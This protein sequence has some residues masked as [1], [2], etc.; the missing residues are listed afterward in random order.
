MK[1]S[2]VI[3]A[4]GKGERMRSSWPKV[5]H[6]V[7]GEAMLSRVVKT[8]QQLDPVDI[9]VVYGSVGSKV[10]DHMKNLPVKWVEQNK[11]LG[12]GHA[13]LQAIEHIAQDHMVL[14]LYADVPLVSVHTLQQLQQHT[15]K[16]GVGVVVAHLDDPTGFGRIVRNDMGHIIGIVEHK[17]ATDVQR[18]IRE[19]N[20]GIMMTQASA[21]HEWLPNLGQQNA[22]GEYYL[23]D[24]IGLAVSDGRSVGGV[25]AGSFEEV[26]GVNN[27]SQLAQVER[28]YQRQQARRLMREGVTLMD[29]SRFDLR[30][31]LSAGQDT[32]IDCNVIVEGDNEWG[33]E[34]SVGAGS[35]LSNVTLGDGVK[36]GAHCVIRD[37]TIAVGTV[38]K[39]HSVIEGAV[40]AEHCTIGPFARIRPETTLAS[41]VR[42]GNFVEVKKCE[43]GEGSK[44]S[45][46]SYLG[47]ALVGREVNVGAGVITANYDGVSK[48]QTVIHD[49]AM[50]GVNSSLVAPVSVGEGATIGAGTVL[51]EDA[52]AE[53]LTLARAKQST[54]RTWKRPVKDEV[55]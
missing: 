47:D 53:Q 8:A 29:P 17:D 37:T 6:Q 10:R 9:Y 31:Q 27:R 36:I 51:T 2:V 54:I 11:C 42:V 39:D 28:Y 7:G 43:L 13:V 18:A 3:L 22:Q 34:V 44:V 15:P 35:L 49:K 21:L 33:S 32:C 1:L 19:V 5:L 24:I 26:M 50:V 20:T 30:G 41:K 52:P 40:I 45:H 16:Q 4:A 12:T 25:M 23:T 14:V 48:H 55:A 38:I 46:L